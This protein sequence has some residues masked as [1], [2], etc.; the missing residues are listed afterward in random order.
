MCHWIILSEGADE[1]VDHYHADNHHQG[2]EIQ[3]MTHTP[4]I[5]SEGNFREFLDRID[6]QL[7]TLGKRQAMAEFHRLLG[8]DHEDLSVLHGEYMAILL[9]ETS[10]NTIETWKDQCTDPRLR[11]RSVIFSKVFRGAQVEADP[12]LF[13]IANPLETRIIS[14]QPEVD[15]TV[16]SRSDHGKILESSPDR[17]L[18]KR[19]YYA[20]KQL[21]RDIESEVLR[22]FAAR[23]TLAQKMG[24]RDFVQYGLAMQELNEETLRDLFQQVRDTTQPTWDRILKQGADALGVAELAPWDLNYYLN[25]VI[26]APKPER[27]PKSRILPTIRQTIRKAGGDLDQLPIH[28][29]ERDIPYGGLCMGIEFGKDVRILANPRDGLTWYD[30]LF[31]EFGH[32]IHSCLLDDSSY[33]VAAGDPP[34]FW[35]GVAGMFERIVHEPEFL[36]KTFDLTSSEIENVLIQNKLQRIRWFRSIAVGCQLEWAVYHGCPDPH[37]T[38]ADLTE[39]YLGIKMEKGVGWAGNTLYT[40]HPLYSQSYL[41]MDVMALQTIE[42]LKQTFGHYPGPELFD[43]VVNHYVKP[44]G[45]IPWHEKIKSAVGSELSADALG[46]Y[47]SIE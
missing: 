35:E 21:D 11:R 19:A 26:P 45:W 13:N 28:V 25:S 34:F 38:A 14:F 7:H 2:R 27:F 47:L 9:N 40:T 23:N 44:A 22:L 12:E 30:A 8:E 43:F 5:T 17:E 20:G 33:L 46:R 18:R 16:I 15:G 24:Y 4:L 31:H 29:Y 39:E 36:V 37:Q 1:S 41:L 32:G 3:T 42:Y 6:Q 10:R